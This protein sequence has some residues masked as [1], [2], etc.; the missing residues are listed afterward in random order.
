VISFIIFMGLP[1]G[2]KLFVITTL[3]FSIILKIY[4]FIQRKYQ[5]YKDKWEAESELTDSEEEKVILAKY[6]LVKK[7]K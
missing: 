2:K 6:N 4:K 5:A 7:V 3:L 1:A